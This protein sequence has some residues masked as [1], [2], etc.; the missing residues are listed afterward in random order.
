VVLGKLMGEC[1]RIKLCD[2]LCT[3]GHKWV[4][5]QRIGADCA[6]QCVSKGVSDRSLQIRRVI[7]A[8]VQF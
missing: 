7:C 5:L 4:E 1:E 3:N 8:G 2:F 6:S